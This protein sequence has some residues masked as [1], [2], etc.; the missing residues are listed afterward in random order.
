MNDIPSQT[1]RHT[2]DA[3]SQLPALQLLQRLGWAWL[4]PEEAVRLRGGRLSAVVLREVLEERLQAINSFEYGGQLRRF[5]RAGI[6]EAVR[7]LTNLPDD[8][9]VMVNERVWHLLRLGKGVPQTVDGDTKSFQL[10]YIDWERPE[11]NAY[12]VTIEFEVEA[13]GTTDTRR[14]DLV[15]FVNGI[16]FV[17]VECK[18]STLPPGKVPID[19]AISQMLR[20]QGPTEIA[21]LF[22]Y[23]QLLLALAV[24]E[25]RYGATGTSLKFWQTWQEPEI[26]AEI[27]SRGLVDASVTAQDRLLYAL[28]RPERL[29]ELSRRF[30]VFDAGV[31]K[32][33]RY[34]QYFAIRAILRHDGP[35]MLPFLIDQGDE[36]RE[37][38]HP[39]LIAMVT[40][41]V[42][43]H[44]ADTPVAPALR[45][46]PPRAVEHL[47]R[48]VFT[49]FLIPPSNCS[50]A[51]VAQLVADAIV[52][53]G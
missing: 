51:D 17:V 26:D 13:S 7:A 32:V 43:P 10:Q 50:H 39:N 21:P 8:G 12:H 2:E 5:D 47:V 35:D 30:T 16:P 42:L 28:C 33:A 29:L 38:G 48:V 37:A 11:R 45:P 9:L 6:E 14:P 22:H 1:P 49:H 53:P 3:V 36:G 46:D 20:N 25:A 18:R 27:A 34:Q 40:A 19:E 4:P 52:N 41:V 15:L 23:A 44:V 24:N 31:R